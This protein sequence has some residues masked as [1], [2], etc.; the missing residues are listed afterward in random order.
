[1]LA[2]LLYL[3][4]ADFNVSEII[5]GVEDTEDIHTVLCSLAAEES[6]DVIGIMLVA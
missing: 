5:E 3:V 2:A 1:M 6:Y 4:N